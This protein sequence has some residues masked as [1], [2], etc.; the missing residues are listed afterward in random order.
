[1]ILNA[2][3][4]RERLARH[5]P[6][7]LMLE[8]RFEGQVSGVGLELRLGTQFV[9]LP[10]AGQRTVA[11]PE[12]R[13]VELGESIS[14][15][16][17]RGALVSTLEHIRLPADLTGLVFPRVSFWRFALLTP[18]LTVDPGFEGKLALPF[19][20]LGSSPIELYSGQPIV[21]VLL[22]ETSPTPRSGDPDNLQKIREVFQQRARRIQA[23]SSPQPSLSELLKRALNTKGPTRGKSLEEFAC[24]MIESIRGLKVLKVNARLK[25]EEIDILV[26]NKVDDAAWT[27]MG[28]PIVLECKNWSGRVGA[29]EISVLGDKLESISPDARTAILIAPFGVSGTSYKDAM[30]KIREKR[31]RGRFIVVLRREELEELTEKTHPA[32]VIERVYDELSLI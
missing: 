28:S 30:L 12:P 11:L 23:S 1:M 4:I 13:S 18:S 26:Q 31:Q 6:L 17:G 25:A 24:R 8:P 32:T 16:G 5:S 19:F 2:N 22:A 14:V 27:R 7:N 20:N 9:E 29:R 10:L 21:R 15:Q 3:Q